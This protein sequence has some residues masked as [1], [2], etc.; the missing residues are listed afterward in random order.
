MANMAGGG[1]KSASEISIADPQITM[2]PSNPNR[3]KTGG[4]GGNGKKR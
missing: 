4:S 1:K 3:N 2:S